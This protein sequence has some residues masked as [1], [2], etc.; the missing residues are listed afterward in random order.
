MRAAVHLALGLAFAVASSASIS[1]AR[2]THRGEGL[3]KAPGLPSCPSSETLHQWKETDFMNPDDYGHTGD[4]ATNPNTTDPE[5][6]WYEDGTG[7][8]P[9]NEAHN[10]WEEEGSSG[11]ITTASPKGKAH[12]AIRI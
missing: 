11:G 6:E 1:E 4:S 8:V 5:G 12:R 10:N 3:L 7:E 2:S 9:E